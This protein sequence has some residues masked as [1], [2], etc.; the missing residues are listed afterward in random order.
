MATKPIFG[1]S[2]EARERT[3][4]RWFRRYGAER[5]GEAIDRS[6]V[7][8]AGDTHLRITYVLNHVLIRGGTKVLIEHTA[9]LQKRGHEVHIVSYFPRPDW[10]EVA[11]DYI[12]VPPQRTLS[13]AIPPSDV[14]VCS[15]ADQ[16]ADCALSWRAPVVHFEQG[17]T[18]LYEFSSLPAPEQERYRRMWALPVPVIAVS[19]G[20]ER[21]LGE[22]LGRRPQRL[23]NALDHAHFFSDARPHPGPPRLLFVGAEQSRFKGVATVRAALGALRV[24][25][26][27]FQ[28][29]WVAPEPPTSLFDGELHVAPSQSQ[30]GEIYRSCDLYLSG[31]HYESFPLPPLEAMACGCAV[32]TTDNVGVREYAR[33]GENCLMAPVGDDTALARAVAQLLDHPEQ[34]AALVAAGL[35]TA[36]RYEWSQ[37]A[38][39][40]EQLLHGAM[41]LWRPPHEVLRIE[42][43][44]RGL[45]LDQARSRVTEVQATMAEP[46]CLWLVEG[47]TI[48]EAELARLRRVLGQPIDDAYAVEVHYADD[49]AVIARF[50]VRLLRRGAPFRPYDE[51]VERAPAQLAG[52]QE[53]YFLP[54]WLATVRPL[55]H[56]RRF[57]DLVRF[58]SEHFEATPSGD[59]P[60]LLKWAALALLEAQVAESALPLVE[61]ALASA[62]HDGDLFYLAG[63]IARAL[64]DRATAQDLLSRASELGDARR[65]SEFFVDLAKL[66]QNS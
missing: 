19:A 28:A 29:V 15:V 18:Y 48:S 63:R 50:E 3:R 2:R 27:D 53:S 52:G 21:A 44:P 65:C 22:A 36:A 39:Q 47:E 41:A 23:P 9:Q 62:P 16:L 4:E 14:I 37:V 49:W 34:R 66:C 30:L 26:R 7:P 56:E 43:L 42:R 31:S 17:D 10:I 51:T 64:G 25:G 6:F 46:W 59:R 45:P 35:A 54:D 32:V 61:N 5:P 1:L 12:Q 13:E 40:L 38:Q 8:L 58:A 55:L 33:A 11:A 60:L 24:Q 57:P 20:L